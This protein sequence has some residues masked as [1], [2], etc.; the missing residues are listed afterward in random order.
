[1]HDPNYKREGFS[2]RLVNIDCLRGATSFNVLMSLERSVERLMPWLAASLAGCSYL[3]GTREISL[4]D[5]GHIVVIYPE[6]MTLTD[7]K[8]PEEA[9]EL[10]N[11]YYQLI[12]EVDACR[13]AWVPVYAKKTRITVLEILKSLPRTNCGECGETTCLAF[14]SR[15]WRREVAVLGC[16]KLLENADDTRSLRAMLRADG[17]TVEDD[18]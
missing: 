12:Q 16:S 5:N 3:H 10:C 18:S 9:E 8:G 6:R 13:D 4:M 14:A 17:Y 11:R 1:M 2:Y 7:V 15:V